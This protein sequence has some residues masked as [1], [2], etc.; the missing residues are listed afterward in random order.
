MG[1]GRKSVP[2]RGAGLAV[3]ALVAAV[4][5]SCSSTP[6]PTASGHVLLV[7]TYKGVAGK[8][9]SIQ[10]AVNAAHP[11]DWILVAP[12]DYHEQ[13]DASSPPTTTQAGDGDMGG[14]VIST[15]DLHLRGMNRNTVIVDGT[16][17]GSP[18]CSSSASDQDF[19]PSSPGGNSSGTSTT[20]ANAYGTSEPSGKADGR[21]GI[22]VWKADNV[23]I[24]NLTVCNFLT[25]AG[26]AGNQIWWNGGAGSGKIG[27]T[28]YTGTYLTA[29]SS[30]YSQNAAGGYGVFSSNS[31]GP[32][33]WNQLYANNE[34]D[35]GMYV[36]ACLQVCAIT[37]DHAWMENNALG[38][39]GTNSGGAV[40]IEHSQF[41]DNQDGADTN[42]QVAGDPPPP[43][44]GDCPGHAISPITHTRSCWVFMDNYVHN[45]NNPNPP[46]AGSAAAGPIGTGITVS[47]G[48]NDTVMDNT[49][50]DNGAWGTLFVPYPDTGTP[51]PGVSCSGSGGHPD[52][53]LGCVYDPEGDAL[54]DNTYTH[55]GYFGNQ[56]NSDFGQITLSAGEPQNCFAGNRAPA[57]SAPADL[58]QTQAKCGALTTSSNTGGPLLDQVECDAGFLPCSSTE[59]YPKRTG[60]TLARVPS[61][62]PTMPNPCVGVPTDPWCPSGSSSSALGSSHR[63]TGAIAAVAIG[64][65]VPAG[66]KVIRRHQQRRT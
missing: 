25:G 24:D 64:T 9:S 31:A 30:Y 39:S 42:T 36:G 37:I 48:R 52:G 4:L 5:T 43:Q 59:V 57:G 11:G 34:N 40:V 35:S 18:P 12:G 46:A 23:E 33:T 3:L 50:A 56:S 22:V 1:R 58:E 21:N 60:T 66:P 26:D 44:N 6:A 51:S 65:V 10:A 38:Y 49:F 62:L 27:L 14:V 29:T 16:K 45:N 8:Y 55:D 7:G 32:A 53:A 17:P 54:L 63:G 13:D 2:A 19:G 20:D 61:D 15:P 41:D 47:G 28:R